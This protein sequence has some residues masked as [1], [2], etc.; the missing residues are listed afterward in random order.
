MLNL[1]L[2][3]WL[4]K[5]DGN[6]IEG[7][8]LWLNQLIDGSCN[9]LW[10]SLEQIIKIL[11]L[12]KDIN[13]YSSTSQNLSELH[14]VIDN[15]G[16]QLGHNVK[17]LIK[18]INTEYPELDISR[19]EQT[20]NKLQ[21]YFYRRYVVHSGSSISPMMLNEIDEDGIDENSTFVSNLPQYAT[22]LKLLKIK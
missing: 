12:Q 9:L 16:K 3:A 22:K 1:A 8:C 15:Q 19:F 20:L 2:N 7:R 17:K 6:Y 11:I 21:E 5:S 13:Q 18:T 4:Q 14:R 10:L